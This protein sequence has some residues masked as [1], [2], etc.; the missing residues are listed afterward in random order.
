MKQIMLNTVF[1]R[2]AL[3]ALALLAVVSCQAPETRTLNVPLL[4]VGDTASHARTKDGLYIS[5]REHLIDD[6]Q[7]NGGTAIRGGDGLAMADLDGDGFLD[8]VSVHEDSNHL[9]IAFGTGNPDRWVNVTVAAG[10]EV[11]AIEDVAI[12]DINGDGWPDLVAACEE[13]HLL[14]LQNPGKLARKETWSRMIPAITQGRGSW[15]RVFMADMDQDGHLD[16]LAANKGST[17]IIDPSL[18]RAARPTSLFR[19]KGD[20]LVQSSWQELVLSQEVVPNT[21]MP[22][23]IDDDGDMDV[24]VAAR[25]DLQMSILETVGNG[26]ESGFAVKPHLISIA[27]GMPVPDGWRGAS[28]AFQSAFADLDGDGRKDLFVAVYETPQPVAGSPL[29]AGLGWLKQPEQ[30]DEP[31]TFFRVGNTLPDI[32]AGIGIADIDG[33][34]DLDAITGG[35]SGLNI[36]RGAYTDASREEDSPQVTAASSVGRIAWFE[37]PGDAREHWERHDISRRVR[38][39]YDVFVPVDMDQDGDIDWVATRGN[40]GIYDGVFWLE[41]VRT[42][43][44]GPAFI[45]GRSEDSRALPLPPENW[46]DTY[47]TEMTFTPPNKVGHE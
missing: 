8:I 41:Q 33:D 34:G 20:P 5:W 14:Y 7:T 1:A 24:L 40:S 6:Q 2:P 21:A 43:E 38:G 19:I 42:T 17:D 27:P 26:A 36:L 22:T 35:Y 44:P 12:G 31:W 30:L 28:N 46:I 13:A 15:L 32:V 10:D 11:G 29:V 16:V 9:R 23:D 3:M 4:A 47:E 18:A 45:A 37:N 39:M 25:L